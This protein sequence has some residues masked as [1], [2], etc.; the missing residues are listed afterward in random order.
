L[1][2]TIEGG[3]LRYLEYLKASGRLP[4]TLEWHQIALR[5][6]QQYLAQHRHHCLFT[7]LSQDDVR[8]WA[9]FLATSPTAAGKLRSS[10]TIAT[11]LRS[12]HA[13]CHWAE[14]EGWVHQSV[15]A[16]SLL[17][18]LPQKALR[19]IEPEEFDRLLQACGPNG[20]DDEPQGWACARNRAIL[21]VL[22]DTGIRVSELCALRLEDVDREAGKLHIGGNRSRER[23]LPLSSQGWQ[24][25]CLYLDQYRCKSASATAERVGGTFL[26]LTE[27]YH[28]FTK[29]ALTLLFARLRTRTGLPQVV[30]RPSSLRD[31]FAVRYLQEGGELEA[32]PD[33]LGLTDL[34]SLKRYVRLLNEEKRALEPQKAHA[35]EQPSRPQPARQTSRRRQRSA[36]SAATRAL[37]QREGDRSDG[38]LGKGSVSD[39]GED[40]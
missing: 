9:N 10:S 29:N 13:F 15:F 25:V 5:S 21:W 26:F 12:V 7:Q 28:P 2:Q 24:Q 18:K 4:K 8:G 3:I 23:H 16:S 36:S 35:E 32:L 38:S 11:Y 22:L 20:K 14:H 19:L 37:R 1:V 33:L 40:P 31:T 30:V 39:A 6:F 17:L 27:T 34:A